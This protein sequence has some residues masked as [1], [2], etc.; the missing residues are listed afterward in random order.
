MSK[1]RITLDGKVYEMEVEL[2]D[3]IGSGATKG[4][5]VRPTQG[6]AAGSAACADVRVADPAVHS[7]THV[8]EDV[9]TSPMPGTVSALL[10]GPG[11][12]VTKGQTVLVLEAM[13]MEN[14]ITAPKDGTIGR[15]FVEER[16]AVQGGVPLFEMA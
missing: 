5:G 3:G 16:Q 6:V 11:Q 12:T 14:D 9:V 15:L 1:Y 10:A 2:L 8:D 7:E 13:K 4:R